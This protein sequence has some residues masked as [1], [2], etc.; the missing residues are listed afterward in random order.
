MLPVPSSTC[1]MHR[2]PRIAKSR[3]GLRR[4][5]PAST[6][7]RNGGSAHSPLVCETAKAVHAVAGEAERGR[8]L[9]AGPLA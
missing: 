8:T 2:V 5:S 7:G 4:H 1:C 6:P 9:S 3:E